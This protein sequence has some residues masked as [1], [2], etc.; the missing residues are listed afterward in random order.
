MISLI[1]KNKWLNSK[2]TN[3]FQRSKQ[4]SHLM[5]ITRVIWDTFDFFLLYKYFILISLYKKLTGSK[6]YDNVGKNLF[7]ISRSIVTRIFVTTQEM[8]S[9]NRSSNAQGQKMKTRRDE[10]FISLALTLERRKLYTMEK[11]SNPLIKL[12][13]FYRF[14]W[15][16]L[17]T[18][19]QSMILL[20]NRF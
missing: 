8:D 5:G 18:T 9:P 14:S 12:I 2:L 4:A 1:G 17:Y 10:N 3:S 7:R 13:E 20:I 19:D 15:K 11:L 16:L 6:R